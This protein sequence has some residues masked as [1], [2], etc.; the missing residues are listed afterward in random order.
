M[1]LTAMHFWTCNDLVSLLASY[2]AALLACTAGKWI[3]HLSPP[4]CSARFITLALAGVT[5]R[6]KEVRYWP[7]AVAGVW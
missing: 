4:V 6:V 7:A 5:E 1:G 3:S 2:V